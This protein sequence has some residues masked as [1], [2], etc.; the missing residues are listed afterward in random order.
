MRKGKRQKIKPKGDEVCA[1]CSRPATCY[2]EIT[3]AS[4]TY[5]FADCFRCDE[6]RKRA[7]QVFRQV[8]VEPLLP[9]APP[10]A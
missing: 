6:H 4:P 9:E 2:V 1:L 3:D 10:K 7:E 8:T 5:K